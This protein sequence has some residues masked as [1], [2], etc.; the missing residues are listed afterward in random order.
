MSISQH[1]PD[2]TDLPNI[3]V[4]R[5]FPQNNTCLTPPVPRVM[6]CGRGQM[7]PQGRGLGPHGCHVRWASGTLISSSPDGTGLWACFQLGLGA[8]SPGG[9]GSMLGLVS[10][11]GLAHP[12]ELSSPLPCCWGVLEDA[13]HSLVWSRRAPE[14][15]VRCAHSLVPTLSSEHGWGPVGPAA[16]RQALSSGTHH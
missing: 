12:G 6:W 4:D 11:R 9:L 5:V 7:A 3:R 14:L 15:G 10:D 2:F 1:T 13:Q 8:H 16:T